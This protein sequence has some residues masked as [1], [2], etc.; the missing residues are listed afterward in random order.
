L[1]EVSK[2]L[3]L[4]NSHNIVHSDLKTENILLRTKRSDDDRDVSF[5]RAVK[6]IDF[7]S[8]FLFTNLK[9]FSMATPEYMPPEILNYILFQNKME[10]DS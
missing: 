2:A 10:Y 4:M 3:F 5:I 6:L 8:S 9:Q 1:I 7:G